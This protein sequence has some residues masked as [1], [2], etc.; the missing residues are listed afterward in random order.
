MIA[1]ALQQRIQQNWQ[2][3]QDDVAEAVRQA[4]R[5]PAEVSI[6]G[7]SKYVDAATTAALFDA[8]CTILGE[9]RPQAVWEKADYFHQRDAQAAGPRWHLIGHLQRNKAKRT[10]P[11][12]ERLHSI[13]SLRLLQTIGEFTETSGTSVTGL[14]EVNVSGEANKTGLEPEQ[15]ASLLAASRQWP[16]LQ[17]AGLMAMA[18]W[19][20]EAAE[21]RRQFA[22][23]RTLRN[24]L[25]GES[26]L[27]LPE[28]SM[29]MSGDFVEAIAEGATLVR[30]GSRLFEGIPRP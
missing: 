30:I 25:R 11:L 20:C 18:G 21:A 17:I 4:G 7:V 14:I 8:G 10:L 23:L 24:T 3:V 5:A 15:A 1:P 2:A 28:L 29:G 9:N 16:K 13:D 6:V 19:G 12:L 26:G 22:A 27:A